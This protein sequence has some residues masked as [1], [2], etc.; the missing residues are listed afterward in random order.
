MLRVG[1]GEVNLVDRGGRVRLKV[2]GA[3]YS[4]GAGYMYLYICMLIATGELYRYKRSILL[5]HQIDRFQSSEIV[6]FH[7]GGEF[8]NTFG[9]KYK[10]CI[11][12]FIYP[13][14]YI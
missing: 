2:G 8:V 13:T 5:Q 7:N 12:S 9:R 4:V 1:M 3:N 6:H 11:F 10:V 14:I